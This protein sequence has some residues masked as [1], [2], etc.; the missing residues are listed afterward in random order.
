MTQLPLLHIFLGI[1][2]ICASLRIMWRAELISQAADYEQARLSPKLY[3]KYA[4][5]EQ[6]R[7]SPL[8]SS[9]LHV[10]TDLNYHVFDSVFRIKF[11]QL[12]FPPLFCL[13]PCY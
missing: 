7:A 9:V 1:R 3:I 11:L 2:E 4:T 6:G 12:D 10:R 5:Q 13:I 8:Q